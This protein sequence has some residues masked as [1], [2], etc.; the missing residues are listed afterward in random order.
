MGITTPFSKK[1]ASE[2]RTLAAVIFD[3]GDVSNDE[4]L[5]EMWGRWKWWFDLFFLCIDR[6]NGNYLHFP[7]GV[8]PVYQGYKTMQILTYIQS[9]YIKKIQELIRRM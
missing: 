9:L 7:N 3:G 6:E 8:I 4:E 1:A 2:I 5:K